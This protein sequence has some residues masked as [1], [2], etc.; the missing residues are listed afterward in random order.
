MDPTIFRTFLNAP[1]WKI[2]HFPTLR[3]N[4]AHSRAEPAI[5][6]P[7]LNRAQFRV[8][9]VIA[10][11]NDAIPRLIRLPSWGNGVGGRAGPI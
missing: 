1:L 2:A 11:F 8:H 9:P 10:F 5:C 3:Y 6:H 4:S 7:A